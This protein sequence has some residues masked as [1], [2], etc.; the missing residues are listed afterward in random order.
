MMNITG[1]L[2]VF[3]CFHGLFKFIYLRYILV[4]TDSFD[5]ALCDASSQYDMMFLYR[6]GHIPDVGTLHLIRPRFPPAMSGKDL[7]SSSRLRAQALIQIDPF[8]SMNL[9]VHQRCLHMLAIN[10]F[11]LMFNIPLSMVPN[12]I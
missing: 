3:R 9:P 12:P 7:G 6:A 4:W 8:P 11:P 2:A 10:L 1:N 5:H